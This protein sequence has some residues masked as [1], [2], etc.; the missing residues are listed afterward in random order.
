MPSFPILWICGKTI[1]KQNKQTKLLLGVAV[2]SRSNDGQI[3]LFRIFFLGIWI[4]SKVTKGWEACGTSSSWVGAL[5]GSFIV[6]LAHLLPELDIQLFLHIHGLSTS[7]QQIPFLPKLAT[8]IF[9]VLIIKGPNEYR[10][11]I[12]LKLCLVV[13]VINLCFFAH[14]TTFGWWLYKGYRN[15]VEINWFVHKSLPYFWS[16]SQAK[17]LDQLYF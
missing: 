2:L 16:F 7:F 10:I 15:N 14:I 3:R 4:L 6:P 1:T 17:C 9:L 5:W 12:I 13:I 11:W 8:V